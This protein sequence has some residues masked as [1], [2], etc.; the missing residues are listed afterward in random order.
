MS[1]S[2]N[3]HSYD[4]VDGKYIKCV[5]TGEY[6]QYN[7]TTFVHSAHTPAPAGSTDLLIIRDGKIVK[8]EDPSVVLCDCEEQHE[9]D[10]PV[11]RAAAL[12]EEA[13]NA[14]AESC[15]CECGCDG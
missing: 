15:D 4:Q 5:E 8:F 7:G 9:E 3:G 13:L 6:L 10:V 1:F 14:Q 2:F 12:I 11:N